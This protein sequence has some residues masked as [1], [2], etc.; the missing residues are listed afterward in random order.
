MILKPTVCALIPVET[1]AGQEAFALPSESQVI[2]DIDGDT[3]FFIPCAPSEDFG[4]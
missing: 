4:C 3:E 2:G 1:G